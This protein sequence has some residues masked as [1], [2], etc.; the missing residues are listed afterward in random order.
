MSGQILA[1]TIVPLSQPV[2]GRNFFHNLPHEHLVGIL[3]EKCAGGGEPP[4][5]L[6][7]SL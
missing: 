4:L 6:A 7:T 5:P 1:L 3:E 2:Y